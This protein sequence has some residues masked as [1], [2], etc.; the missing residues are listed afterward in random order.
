MH[1]LD[2]LIDA[3]HLEDLKNVEHPSIFDENENYDM[4][5][6]RLPVIGE[7]LTTNSL[8]F[9]LPACKSY[10][11]DKKLQDFKELGSKFEGPYRMLDKYID[12]LLKS[13]TKYKELTSDMEEILYTHQ[14]TAA[15][16]TDWLQ[17]KQNIVR[18]ERILMRTAETMEDVLEYYENDEAF[19]MNNY[20]DLHE[21][22]DRVLRSATLQLSKL[23]YLYS[24]YNTRTSEKMN[25]SVYLLTVISAIFLPLNLVVGFFGMN[26]SGLPFSGGEFGTLSA[27]SLMISL[28]VI[29]SAVAYIWQQRVDKS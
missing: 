6:V 9:I 22:I 16:M 12:K 4:L 26:T 10:F 21:H 13:F 27:I 18:I 23:D 14:E 1:N 5:I 24:Y 8:S 15:F 19:P 7:T 3:L 29:T 17:L 28:V 20:V 25:K 2:S 11:Y